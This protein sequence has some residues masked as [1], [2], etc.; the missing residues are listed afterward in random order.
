MD[1][2]N[3]LE[4]LAN[5]TSYSEDAQKLISKQPDEIQKIFLANDT[6]S[7]KNKFPNV[8]YLANGTQVIEI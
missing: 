5:Y 1:T 6:E 4:Q 2:V 7:I 3:F 8:E